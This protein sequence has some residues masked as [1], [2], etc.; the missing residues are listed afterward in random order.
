MD[1][2]S[3]GLHFQDIL[4]LL[5]VLKKLVDQGNTVLIIEHNI[6][7]IKVADY[8]I[9]MGPDGGRDG[10]YLVAAGTP[11]A[12]ARVAESHTGYFLKKEL[13]L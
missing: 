7:M 11:E 4:A 8:V 2:P 1:E 6:D 9:D 12:V 10:G 13:G 5:S 3:T